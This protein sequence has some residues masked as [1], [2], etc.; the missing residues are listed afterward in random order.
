MCAATPP[1]TC[2]YSVFH[3]QRRSIRTHIFTHSNRHHM[4]PPDTGG[5]RYHF[6]GLYYHNQKAGSRGPP[7]THFLTFREFFQYRLNL[8]I[9]VLYYLQRP[10]YR[11]GLGTGPAAPPGVAANSPSIQY[12]T[13]IPAGPSRQ[14]PQGG[15][16]MAIFKNHLARTLPALA[17]AGLFLLAGCGDSTSGS[18]SSDGSSSTASSGAA[19]SSATNTQIGRASCRERV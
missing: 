8:S 19:D 1:K 2:L 16:C 12:S 6:L 4:F 14:A 11:G 7:S 18:S 17:L 15:I 5:H 10:P 13:S 9:C 3:T